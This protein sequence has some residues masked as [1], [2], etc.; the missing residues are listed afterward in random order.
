[1]RIGKGNLIRVIRYSIK[2]KDILQKTPYVVDMSTIKHDGG[3]SQYTFLEAIYQDC[4]L[5]LHREWVNQG[6]LWKEGV[7]CLAADTPEELASLLK[8]I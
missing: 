6:T 8:R 5:I 2:E 7:N 3:G 4:V 1:M